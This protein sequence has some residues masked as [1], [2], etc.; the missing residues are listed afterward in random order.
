MK[1]YISHGWAEKVID[2]EKKNLQEVAGTSASTVSVTSDQT[3]FNTEDVE[4][5]YKP[6]KEVFPWGVS[7]MSFTNAEI[8]NYFVTRTAVDGLPAS[9][10]KGMNASALNL[11]QC[12]HIQ[13]ISVCINITQRRQFIKCDCIPEMRKDRIYKVNMVI[14]SDT[15][16][17]VGARCGCPAGKGPC[18]TCKHVG[19]LCYALEEYCRLGRTPDYITCT[20]KL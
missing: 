20:E 11:F 15:H 4:T 18:A 5:A 1:A 17:I 6:L 16:N 13:S 9:D 19:G 14:D 10:V 3:L 8:I 7:S 2:P 12:S